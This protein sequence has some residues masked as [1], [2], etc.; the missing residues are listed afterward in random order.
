MPDNNPAVIQQLE[1]AKQQDDHQYEIAK[2][3]IEKNIENNSM[4]AKHFYK[5]RI[6]SLVFSFGVLVVVAVF[7]SVAML[8]NKD[9]IAMEIIK[10]LTVTGASGTAGYFYGLNKGKNE[11][12]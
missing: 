9:S 7:C 11:P 3:G 6:A 10:I 4:W 2:L 12:K 5:T 8:L 1:L